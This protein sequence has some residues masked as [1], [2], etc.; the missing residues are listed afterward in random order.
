MLSPQRL[1]LGLL[2]LAGHAVATFPSVCP[3]PA[4]SSS[5]TTN[6]VCVQDFK[7]IGGALEAV[8]ESTHAP[9]GLAVDLDENIYLTYPRNFENAT[10]AVTIASSFTDE[11]PW[12]SAEIQNCQPGQNVSEC[13]INI[14]N[15]VLDA[16]GQFWVLDSGIP[17]KKTAPA[18]TGGAKIMQFDP[19]TKELVKTYLFPDGILSSGT[20]LNDL[21][22]NNTAG[23]GGFA[24]LTDASV[25]GGILA[26]DLATGGVVKR[27]AGQPSV[28]ADPGYVGSYNGE[29]IYCWNGTAKS[30]C[31]TSSDG[32]ALQ[33]GQ[34]YWGVLSSRR[35]YYVPQEVLQNFDATDDE[36]LAA[37]QDPGQLGSEQAGFTADDQGRVFLLASEQNAIYYVQTDQSRITEEVN[38]VP[39]GGSGPVATENYYVKTLVRNGL[40][41][42]ADS[43]AILNGYLYFCTNQLELGPS[44]Q[45]KNADNR[46][47]PF[48]SYKLFIGAGPAV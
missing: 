37:V 43:A 10:N 4:L 30:F 45:Y 38:G 24:F 26:V 48:R 1:V 44:R 15:L 2:Y 11:E 42:H 14:Q 28:M 8:H 12:P 16:H 36:V 25:K 21:R 20:N 13:F 7:I 39:A 17:Y 9:T 46:K 29:P 22:I 40:I 35:F 18:V 5:N 34:I 27:L 23:T 6:G 41:Q 3:D 31:T 47:G 19:V 32:I 33:G